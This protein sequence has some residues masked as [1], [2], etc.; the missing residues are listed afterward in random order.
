MKRLN[1]K[2]FSAKEFGIVVIGIF[3][4]VMG[5]MPIVFKMIEET[6]NTAVTDSVKAFKQQINM[7][8]FNQVNSGINV[9]NGCYII[10]DEGD[11]CL[12]GKDDG[13]DTGSLDIEM[14]GLKPSGGYVSIKE[15]QVKGI[16]NVF[17]D[18]KYVNEKNSEYYVSENPDKKIVCE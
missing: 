18:N 14:D 6:R 15:Y 13:C 10:T 2:G 5:I 11:L 3:V 16:Y 12:D 8:I 4:A 1:N 9:E 17:I 7:R